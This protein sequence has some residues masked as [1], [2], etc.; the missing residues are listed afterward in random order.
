[1]MLIDICLLFGLPV[2]TS[3]W[4]SIRGYVNKLFHL[5]AYLL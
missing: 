3:R 2:Y 1:M 5:L 4:N